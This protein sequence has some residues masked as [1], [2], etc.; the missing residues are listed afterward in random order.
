MDEPE[1]VYDP[2]TWPVVACSERL[3]ELREW[4]QANGVDPC[5]VPVGE[6]ITLEP[7]TPDGQR[8]IHFTAYLRNAEGR[9]YL[10][11]D[12]QGPA[13]EARVMPLVVD[14]PPHWRTRKESQ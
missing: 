11:E 7:L 8:A 4:L 10:D 1:I 3:A 2:D 6:E 9:F 13:M 5:D 14:P 12:T